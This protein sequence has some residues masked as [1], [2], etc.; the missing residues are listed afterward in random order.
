[1]IVDYETLE[2]QETWAKDILDG[3]LKE[4]ELEEEKR[5]FVDC[6]FGCSGSC[7]GCSGTTHCGN[8]YD[9]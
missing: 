7:E 4:I 5:V 8:T 9:D 2:E 1:M 3:I 6:Y